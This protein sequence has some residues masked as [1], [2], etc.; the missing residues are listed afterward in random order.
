[1]IGPSSCFGWRAAVVAFV[2]VE[3][4][5]VVAADGRRAV[6][7]SHASTANTNALP[8]TAAIG[9]GALRAIGI[10]VRFLTA[11]GTVLAALVRA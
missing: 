2:A 5:D 8:R 4:A 6:P 7:P 10:G 11:L 9:E 3:P 1:M